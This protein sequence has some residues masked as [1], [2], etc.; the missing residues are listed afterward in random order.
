[1][2]AAASV[3]FTFAFI[4]TMT[5]SSR[6]SGDILAF[7]EPGAKPFALCRLCREEGSRAADGDARRCRFGTLLL[8]FVN[9]IYIFEPKQKT[10]AEEG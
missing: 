1:M 3:V 6:C 8:A 5:I 2:A 10:K 7:L 4:E 9:H